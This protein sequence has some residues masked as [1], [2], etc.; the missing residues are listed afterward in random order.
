MR[1]KVPPTES[2][3]RGGTARARN[4]TARE[5]TAIGK[6]G[7]FGR[8]FPEGLVLGTEAPPLQLGF[9]SLESY[10]L[11]DGRRIITQSAFQGGIGLGQRPGQVGRARVAKFL[12]SLNVN[13]VVTAQAVA[14]V[15][16]P[17]RFGRSDG[18][19]DAG[20]DLSLLPVVWRLVREADAAGHV[21]IRQ[22]HVA[23]HCRRLLDSIT[24]FALLAQA[25]RDTTV[26]PAPETAHEPA[27]PAASLQRK[28]R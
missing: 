20:Y 19:L 8:W 13:R 14:R 3:R 7:A 24:A 4:L 9:V 2:G 21:S 27:L 28:Q 22:R 16:A 6:E 25:D 11:A 26:V 17:V 12:S 15:M 5:L 18:T 23:A 1:T 10:R